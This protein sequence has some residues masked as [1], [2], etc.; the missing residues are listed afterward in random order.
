ME[1]RELFCTVFYGVH[2]NIKLVY[3]VQGFLHRIAP[4][5]WCRLQYHYLDRCFRSMNDEQKAYVM[6]RVDYYCKLQ[7]HSSLPDDAMVLKNHTYKNKTGNS[8]YFLDTF[9]FT[10]LFPLHYKWL[11][12]PGDI[13]TTFDYPTVVK[14]RPIVAKDNPENSVLLNMDKVRHFLFIN[15]PVAWDKKADIL[16]FR[17]A[18]GQ[19]ELNEFKRNRF[20]F[21]TK[22]FD[23]PLCDLGEIMEGGKYIKKEWGK[24]KLTI[25]QHLSYKFIMA[26]E[27]NDVASNLKWIMS[28]NSIAVMP[29]PTCE[30]WFMEGRLIPDYHY[31]KV[32]A[33]FSDVEERIRYYLEHPEE[34]KAIIEHAHEYVKQFKNKKRERI[35][36]MLVMKKYFK[37]TNE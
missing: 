13:T 30:T 32:A 18:I 24:P 10:R 12:A 35:I 19:K 15:D 5:W 21:M 33:D 34:A 28:S 8:V 3:Y 25:F 11:T 6:D 27:G 26:L 7:N 14:S 17:G 20:D 37:Y 29:E 9:E 4:R 16:L 1:L 22:Y 2:K 31:I 36:S 23:N